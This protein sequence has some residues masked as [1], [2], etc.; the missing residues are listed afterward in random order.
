MNITPPRESSTQKVVLYSYFKGFGHATRYP[1][2]GETIGAIQVPDCSSVVFLL[3]D[4][5]LVSFDVSDREPILLANKIA[6]YP[7]LLNFNEISCD[8]DLSKVKFAEMSRKVTSITEIPLLITTLPEALSPEWVRI[9]SKL[10]SGKNPSSSQE[11]LWAFEHWRLGFLVGVNSSTADGAWGD[12]G[13]RLIFARTKEELLSA[14]SKQECEAALWIDKGY[15]ALIGKDGRIIN[16]GRLFYS[17]GDF[18]IT[19]QGMEISVGLKIRPQSPTVPALL[20]V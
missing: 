18:K 5:T 7:F 20:K 4:G 11:L 6:E 1:Q 8:I 9:R 16:S 13:V 2:N 10:F 15:H 14:A 19:K 3:E 17:D 12:K